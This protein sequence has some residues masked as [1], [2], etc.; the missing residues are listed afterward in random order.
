VQEA[1]VARECVCSKGPDE[2]VPSWC[3]WLNV[4]VTTVLGGGQKKRNGRD[5]DSYTHCHPEQFY[6]CALTAA[7]FRANASVMSSG[8]WLCV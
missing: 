3:E 5:H 6:V 7:R 1:V 2:W 8:S 4:P